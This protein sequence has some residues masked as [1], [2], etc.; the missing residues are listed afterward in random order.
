ML[1]NKIHRSLTSKKQR[2]PVDIDNLSYL[3]RENH[4]SI[5][6]TLSKAEMHYNVNPRHQSK[7]VFRRL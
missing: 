4:S 5:F 3:A 1:L 6:Q 7:D 2:L